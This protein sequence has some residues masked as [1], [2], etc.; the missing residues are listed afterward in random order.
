MD[1]LISFAN[2]D[3]GAYA[4]P[5][6]PSV[7]ITNPPW[8]LRLDGA[9]AAWEALGAFAKREMSEG[10]VWALSGNPEVSRHSRLKASLKIPL[11]AAAV[12]MRLLRYDIRVPSF[13]R[14]T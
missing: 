5:V 3:A 11:K 2:G 14:S 13:E 4:P 12:D 10:V 6:T 1:R 9:P 8:D 7:A